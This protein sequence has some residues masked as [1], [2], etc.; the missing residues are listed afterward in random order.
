MI[1]NLQELTGV[2]G[3]ATEYII[4]QACNNSAEAFS[5]N[6]SDIA[7]AVG[8]EKSDLLKYKDFL[9]AELQ[10]RPEAASVELS[11]NDPSAINISCHSKYR[12]P[13]QVENIE[14]S[15]QLESSSSKL[16]YLK[17][18][19]FAVEQIEEINQSSPH[20]QAGVW[21]RRSP[22]F[23][24]HTVIQDV[25][26]ELAQSEGTSA[27]DD[28]VFKAREKAIMTLLENDYKYQTLKETNDSSLNE[29][30]DLWKNI[31]YLSFPRPRERCIVRY[32]DNP[33][34]IGRMCIIKEHADLDGEYAFS[35]AWDQ[36]T[37]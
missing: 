14:P 7:T 19:D 18:T 16:E 10:A 12:R 21:Q 22:R 23:Q 6:L 5:I 20:K 1:N 30:V 32:H 26:P 3:A 15:E 27:S 36:S 8:A 35:V 9:V 33:S 31:A 25:H 28:L 4:K 37:Q 13:A 24:E 34:Y 29:Y 17:P 11:Q 2:I